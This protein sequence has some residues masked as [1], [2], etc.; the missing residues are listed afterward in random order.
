FWDQMENEKQYVLTFL[1]NDTLGNVQLITKEDGYIIVKDEVEPDVDLEIPTLE[2]EWSFEDTFTISAFVTDGNG[3]GI[4]SVELFYRYS[5]D[6]DFNGTWISYGVLTSEP[7]EWEFEAD[8]GNGHYEFKI[9]AEDVAGNVAGSEVKEIFINIFPTLSV[10]VML[11][12]II[13]LILITFVI[14]IKWRKK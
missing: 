6:G 9:V 13:A 10:V 1:I 8:E 7:F 4:K 11:I 12:L 3:S 5:E 2:T 14:F